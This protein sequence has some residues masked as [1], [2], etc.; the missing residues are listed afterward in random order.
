MSNS[1]ALFEDA[2]AVVGVSCRVAGAGSAGELW[3]VVAAGR[4]VVG[5]VP[6]GRGDVG[7]VRGGFLRSVDGFDA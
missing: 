4:E 5:P 6:A 3:D 1:G 7:V 2:V